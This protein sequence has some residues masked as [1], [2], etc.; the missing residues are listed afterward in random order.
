M[1]DS[2]LTALT[3]LSSLA[4]TDL[5]YVVDVSDT[6]DDASG[7]SRQTSVERTMGMAGI[8]CG[9][10]LTT[11]S[12]VSVSTS[13]RTSQSTIY[14]EPHLT[15]YLRLFDGSR[16]KEYLVSTPPSFT[17]SG[18]A[19]QR[20][21]LFAYDNGGTLALEPSAAWASAT[22]RTDAVVWQPGLGPIK[23][24]SPTR[25]HV[26]CFCL[27]GTNVIED[28]VTKRF[29]W[30]A[31]N[32]VVRALQKFESTTSWSFSTS[33]Y[34]QVNN[35]ADNRV[36]A[37]VGDTHSFLQ[38]HVVANANGTSTADSFVTAIGT[39][40]T[41]APDSDCMM[42]IGRNYVSG[43]G[44]NAFAFVNRQAAFGYHAYNWLEWAAGGGTQTW[45]GEFTSSGD[46][47][48]RTGIQGSIEC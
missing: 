44:N 37:I 11:E 8:V 31:Q 15:D 25:A 6:T 32:K 23:S 10:R 16:I 19:G 21:D 3:M 38:L 20:F 12:G 35:S 26:G 29:L 45:T 46:I 17:V 28:S 5:M 27:S 48:R 42:V 18:S 7:S 41:T 40:S 14:L 2:R 4:L 43:S 39:D 13:D 36:E 22:S 33:N 30:N 47:V 9:Q 1:A 34:R 24:G